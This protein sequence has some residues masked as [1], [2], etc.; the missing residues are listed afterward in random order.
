MT[1]SLEQFISQLD[2]SGVL[3]EQDIAAFQESH[4]SD[5]ETAEDLGKLLVK[6]KKVTKLQ[7]QMVYQGKGQLLRLGNYLIQDKIG[8]GGMGDV[9]LAE[10]SR[11]QRKVA[12][13]VLP[14]A[15]AEDEKTIRR[16]QR[17]VQAAAKL[18]HSNIVT[19]FDADEAKGIHYLVMEYVDGTDLSALVKKQGVLSV[20]Q[21]LDCILQAARGLEYAHNKGVIHRD[22]KPSNLLLDSEGTVKILDMGLARINNV[23]DENPVTAL[24]GSES[25]MGTVDYMSP[26]QAQSTH[27]ADCRS[28]IYSL[29]CSLYYL[30]TGDSVYGGQTVVNRIL[31]HRDQPIPSLSAT[32]GHVPHD[33]DAI[34]QKMIAKK[35]EDRFQTMQEVIDAIENCDLLK[36]S[37]KE[38]TEPS[39]PELHRF[40]Q[41]QKIA[42]SPTI[43]MSTGKPLTAT[44]DQ[45]PPAGFLD[46]TLK[47]TAFQPLEKRRKSSGRQRWVAAGVVL[48]SLLLLA[49]IVFKIE[50]PAGTVILEVDQPEMAGAVVSVDDQKK[51][52]INTGEDQEQ[53]TVEADEKKHTL[54]VTK[55]GFETF[56]RQFTVKAGEKETIRVRL[57]PLAVAQKPAEIMP[58]PMTDRQIIEWVISVGGSVAI[59][60]QDNYVSKIEELPTGP[61]YYHCVNLSQANFAAHDLR[62]LSN[63]TNLKTI[64]LD[65]TAIRDKDLQYLKG[66]QNLVTLRLNDTKIT[67]EGLRY[68]NE[69]STLLRL[70]LSNTPVNNAGMEQISSLKHLSSLQLDKTQVGDAGMKQIDRLKNLKALR[71][72]DTQISDASME[73]IG[74]LKELTNLYVANTR[75]S[76]AGLQHITNLSN[77]QT[78]DLCGTRFDEAGLR[79]IQKLTNLKNLF[80]NNCFGLN[81][82]GLKHI[83]A[84][85]G[86]SQ[87]Y[88]ANTQVSEDGIVLIGELKNL[89]RLQMESLSIGDR[90]LQQISGLDNLTALY[91]DNNQVT[92]SGLKYLYGLK[93]LE[94]LAIH[95]TEVT[96]QGIADL[97]KALPNCKIYSDFESQSPVNK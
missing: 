7:A 47:G 81:D 57:I 5:V 29:G 11:M 43:S 89:T 97:Q 16:F 48:V 36:S 35:P 53:I 64:V 50:T 51:I 13:K 40:L 59:N 73:P 30:V 87:L 93:K 72:E 56:T 38:N 67:G 52:T 21:T 60:S 76:N 39:N 3:S 78:L 91:L 79:D 54:K 23:D 27:T 32:H 37:S 70:E 86:L 8:S 33:V 68:L 44:Q 22:I 45:T 74:K 82:E 92:D 24:T 85:K 12:L 77:L 65:S 88:I 49:G 18:S 94:G 42:S 55:A 15:M 9:Y 41:S 2:E 71:L 6:H 46:N 95:E 62:R 4:P 31:A 25:V 83:G 61:V 80:L 17:E 66:I 75:I 96:P 58:F 69:L 14:K 84:L 34:Y 28:D 90:A 63:L 20:E 1:I 19:A 26:E 10:H